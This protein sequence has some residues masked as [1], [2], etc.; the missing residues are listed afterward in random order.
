MTV[1]TNKLD[2]RGLQYHIQEWG[3]PANPTLLMLHGWMDCGASFKFMAP[4]LTDHFHIVAPDL[5]GFGETQHAQNG[6]FFPDYFADLEVIVNYYSPQSAIRLVGHSMGGQIALMY[7]GIRPDRVSQLLSLEAIGLPPTASTDAPVRYRDWMNQI[8]SDEPSKVYPNIDFLKQ[9]IHKGN[10]SLSSAMI[11]E[12]A[13]LWG[14]A[15]GDEGAVT[16]KHDHAHRYTNP[17]RYQH[18]DVLEVWKQIGARVGLVM[19][20]NSS[21]YK[22]FATPQRLQ[23]VKQVL[24]ISEADYF[25][26]ED[27]HHM[28][29]LEQPA[30]TADCVLKFFS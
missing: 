26:V 15:V 27:S 8:L 28:L 29:H 10:P 17:V 19:A 9:S 11:D 21:M 2:V 18:D 7:A 4:Y 30:Q 20:L 24:R 3:D 12:L 1:T 14:R 22:R 25:L 5:R 23:Q 6:Y 16:L 13:E